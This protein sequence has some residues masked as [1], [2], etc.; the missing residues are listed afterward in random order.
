MQYCY[1]LLEQG[2]FTGHRL[3]NDNIALSERLS[4]NTIF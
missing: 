4:E 3:S 1:E 2:L